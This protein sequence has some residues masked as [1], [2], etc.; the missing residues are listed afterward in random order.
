MVKLRRKISNIN[1]NVEHLENR[2]NVNDIITELKSLY[3]EEILAWYQYFI[4]VN[5]LKGAQRKNVEDTFKELGNDEL[6]DHAEKLLRRIAELEGDIE[7]IDEFDK[8]TSIATTEYIKP[9]KGCDAFDLI[10]SNIDSEKE[11]IEHYQRVADMTRDRDYTTH[12]LIL[13]ILADEEEHLRE[14]K[15]F[16]QDISG[17]EFDMNT[18]EYKYDPNVV[19]YDMSTYDIPSSNY[20]S[21]SYF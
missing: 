2:I 5:F 15:D 9:W 7:G 14:L 19:E 8:I 10:R 3:A 16:Y 20:V 21:N 17:L 11:A 18:D 6:H 13:E 1:E 12:S 4:P